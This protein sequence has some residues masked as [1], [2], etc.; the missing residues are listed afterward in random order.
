MK[1]LILPFDINELNK[2]SDVTINMSKF[3]FDIPRDQQKKASF[4]FLR[5]MGINVTLDFSDCSYEDKEEFLLLYLTENID[6]NAEILA[7]TW[8][9][10][11][12]AKDGGG[13]NLPSIFTSE[14]IEKFLGRNKKF[15]DEIFRIINSIPICSMIFSKQNGK[16]Y[17]VNEFKKSD[18]QGLS[19]INFCKLSRFDEFTLLIDGSVESIFYEKLFVKNPYTEEIVKNT[20]FLNL[21]ELFNLTKDKQDSFVKEVDK[22]I[23]PHFDDKKEGIK[24]EG[25]S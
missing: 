12:S 6:V 21:L 4:I 19:M 15:V 8:I 2:I 11:L 10:I 5:N 20:P 18:Y 14:E 17:D 13:V 1:S 7:S 25:E 23:T 24:K 16:L 3:N 22:I 9:E